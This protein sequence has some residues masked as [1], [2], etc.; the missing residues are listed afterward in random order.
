M[1]GIKT[2]RKAFPGKP[3]LV[4]PPYGGPDAKQAFIP[5]TPYG[6]KHLMG[7]LA[8]NLTWYVL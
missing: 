3:Q 8:T 4:N 5:D 6:T 1:E 7:I 2:K